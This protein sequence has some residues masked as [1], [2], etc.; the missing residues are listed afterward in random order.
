[1]FLRVSFLDKS[2]FKVKCY[3]TCCYDC[4]RRLTNYSTCIIHNA[5]NMTLIIFSALET[6]LVVFL[7]SL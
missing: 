1:M 7:E 4:N 3:E 6:E 2:R 5:H